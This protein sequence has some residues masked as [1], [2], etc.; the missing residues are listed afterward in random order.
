MGLRKSKRLFGAVLVAGLIGSASYAMTASNTFA[1]ATN[2]A[3]SGN[4]TISGFAVSAVSY[5]LDA[6]NPEA[7]SAVNF[8]LDGTAGDVR[9][10]VTAAGTTYAT[11]TAGASNSWTCPITD[12]VAD[13][14]QLTVIAVQ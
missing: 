9:A 12:D 10:K 13:A 2:K 3:G 1:S 5:T 14:D 7:Y 6:T 8:T 4:Q 11:C